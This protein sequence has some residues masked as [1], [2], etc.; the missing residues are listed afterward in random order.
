LQDDVNN[1][2]VALSIKATKLTAKVLAKAFL[3]VL[4]IIKKHHQ[5]A[6]T[7][8]GRQS[9]KKLM[10]HG[11]ATNALPLDGDTKLFDKVAWKWGVDYSLHKTGPQK[12]LLLFKSGQADAITAAFAEYSKLVMARAKDKRLPIMEQL[13]QFAERVRQQPERERSKEAARDER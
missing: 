4:R 3:G 11:Q 5:K 8:Q 2:T 10:N 13:K 7:P 6:Q 1:K 12:Y 9:V